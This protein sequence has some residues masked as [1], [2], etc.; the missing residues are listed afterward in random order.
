MKRFFGSKLLYQVVLAIAVSS[1]LL[2]MVVGLV[3]IRNSTLHVEEEVK[4]KYTF[5]VSDYI[6]QLDI[7]VKEAE[8]IVNS[9][10]IHLSLE[11][12]MNDIF[13]DPI[14]NYMF[15]EDYQKSINEVGLYDEYIY[16]VFVYLQSD[17]RNEEMIIS[18]HR[19][20]STKLHDEIREMASNAIMDP[21]YNENGYWLKFGDK[22]LF[23]YLKPIIIDDKIVGFTGGRFRT[24]GFVWGV[25]NITESIKSD[26]I[27][28]D[29]SYEPLVLSHYLEGTL[30]SD[31]R[32]I[33][34]EVESV[35]SGILEYTDA[36]DRDLIVAYGRLNNEWLV[37]IKMS[38]RDV[39]IR[40]YDLF[41]LMIMLL[42]IGGVFS[43]FVAVSISS[44]LTEPITALAK[45]MRRIGE[46][47]Y[48]TQ[49]SDEYMIYNNEIGILA[50]TVETMRFSLSRYIKEIENNAK[51]LENE[52]EERTSELRTTN[53][54]LEQSLAEI[55]ERKAE[56]ILVNDELEQTLDNLRGTQEQLIESRKL[57]A[58]SDLV[59]GV[60]HQ[61]NTPIGVSITA[62]SYLK[63]ELNDFYKHMRKEGLLDDV[64]NESLKDIAETTQLAMKN[65][66]KARDTLD[67]FKYITADSSSEKAKDLDL[68]E[69]FT[70]LTSAL[71]VK[72]EYVKYNLSFNCETEIMLKSYP[73][74]LTQIM[75]NLIS[76][77]V[78]HGF[79]D[80]D[81]GNI[82]IVL[83]ENEHYVV[84]DYR[85]DGAGIPDE[86]AERIFD[87]FFTTKL[88]KERIGLGLSIVYNYVSVKMQGRIRCE[89]GLGKGAHFIIQI[90]K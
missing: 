19:A 70:D 11:R 34:T 32:P 86:N 48:D 38:K 41:K 89:A 65:L 4:E 39:L 83:S 25:D 35:R 77:S 16:D 49:L 50:T 63:K 61:L 31:I 53:E 46:G 68:C 18:S 40:T 51:N 24:F 57:S 27:L 43:I 44:R 73:S 66:T 67:T 84:I 14:S 1:I 2:S 20:P 79:R 36:E 7:R 12:N 76:N 87:P 15:F 6:H 74:I 37:V 59:N 58:L 26:L 17:D 82:E 80:R 88:G 5:L 22:N 9:I 28:Y 47:D 71:M 30:I 55:E 8:A 72:A 21:N 75:S 60:A 64:L 56:L 54:Y 69:F 33:Y 42:L 13:E 3:L 90:P 52:V 85:D 23:C 78:I 29:Q 10:N 45:E 62:V 81:N